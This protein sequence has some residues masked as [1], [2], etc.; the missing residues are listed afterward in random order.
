MT[1]ASRAVRSA[2]ALAATALCGSAQAR[3]V[4]DSFIGIAVGSRIDAQSSMAGNCDGQPV[5]GT[6][7]FDTD[8]P[9]PTCTGPDVVQTANLPGTL[10]LPDT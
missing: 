3:V 7:S 10:T 9:L 2:L 4:D 5:T 6:F 1:P 8:V